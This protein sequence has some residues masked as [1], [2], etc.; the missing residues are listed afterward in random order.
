MDK[1]Q[2]QIRFENAHL[3]HLTGWWKNTPPMSLGSIMHW[4][5]VY[6]NLHTAERISVGSGIVSLGG[7]VL[8]TIDYNEELRMPIFTF[9]ENY[10]YMADAQTNYLEGLERYKDVLNFNDLTEK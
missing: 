5:Y 4:I 7:D 1:T 10:K 8:A 3:R 6:S 2:H 9:S